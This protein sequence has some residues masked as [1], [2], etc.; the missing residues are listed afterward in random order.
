[1]CLYHCQEIIPAAQ[2]P[3]RHRMITRQ[4][5]HFEHNIGAAI[6]QVLSAEGGGEGEK[7]TAVV[8][9]QPSQLDNYLQY[10]QRECLRGRGSFDL[11]RLTVPLLLQVSTV[12]DD[13]HHEIP[14]MLRSFIVL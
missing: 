8:R 6:V 13:R 1:M 7:W 2:S 11:M 14:I 12:I 9:E 4:L 5:P 3:D 10:A